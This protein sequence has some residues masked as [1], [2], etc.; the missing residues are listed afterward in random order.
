MSQSQLHDLLDQIPDRPADHDRTVILVAIDTP[1]ADNPDLGP[2]GVAIRDTLID[3]GVDPATQVQY[4]PYSYDVEEQSE[5]WRTGDRLDPA[6]E[7]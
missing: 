5:G 7:D 2:V 6:E 4:L 1:S 3:A